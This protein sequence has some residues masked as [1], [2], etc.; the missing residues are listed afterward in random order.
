MIGILY[1]Y[2]EGIPVYREKQFMK[3]LNVS[4]VHSTISYP[5]SEHVSASLNGRRTHNICVFSE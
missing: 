1:V 3:Y 2:I 4:D 5:V